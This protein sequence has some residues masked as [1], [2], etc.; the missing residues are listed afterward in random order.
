MKYLVPYVSMIG[1]PR[2]YDP[3]T[4]ILVE[5]GVC[6]G[7]I[8]ADGNFESAKPNIQHMEVE[9]ESAEDALE[10]ARFMINLGINGA[11]A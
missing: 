9:A 11:G 10:Q 5:D 8:H 7:Y 6:V 1:K 3:G 2:P 4:R